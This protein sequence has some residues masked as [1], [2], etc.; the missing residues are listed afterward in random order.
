MS[1]KISS[2]N[3]ASTIDSRD[4]I[5]IAGNNPLTFSDWGGGWFMQDGTYVRTY[6]QKSI[7][8]GDGVL[9]SQGGLSVGYGG[10][11]PTAGYGIIAGRLG[12]GTSSPEQK[13][14]VEGTI[15]L[16]NQE[17]LAWAYDDGNYYN[18]Q[19][20]K[21][22]LCNNN[23]ELFDDFIF[24]SNGQIKDVATEIELEGLRV[25]CNLNGGAKVIGQ[26][27]PDAI[28]KD[29]DQYTDED[30]TIIP[31]C[32]HYDEKHLWKDCSCKSGFV[33]GVVIKNKTK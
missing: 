21:Y 24:F 22:F 10:T 18:C 12:I 17:N 19:R 31:L 14:H 23:I 7:W 26:I 25:L 16:G 6:N 29:G 5:T 4:D 15:Q 20:Y 30:I 8:L 33:D 9:A 2:L 27:D 28:V 3:T 11:L 13:L 1:V 32:P